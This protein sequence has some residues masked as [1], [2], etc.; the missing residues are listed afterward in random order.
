MTLAQQLIEA[1]LPPNPFP[2]SKVQ[3]PVYHSTGTVFRRFNPKVSMQGIIWFTSDREAALR[4][5]VGASRNGHLITAY[6]NLTKP[7]G[8]PEY[9]RLMLA[10]L[11]NDGFD[12]AILPS[13]NRF[14]CFVFRPDQIKIIRREDQITSTEQVP[15]G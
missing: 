6:V 1:A 9:K 10:Q 15:R 3:Q 13:E 12:G 2:L 7:A 5:E 8:W 14:N 11:K 4:Q